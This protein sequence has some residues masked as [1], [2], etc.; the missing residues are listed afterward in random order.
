M[1]VLVADDVRLA[2][3]RSLYSIAGVQIVGE[4]R[5]AE[6]AE[7]L[8]GFTKPDVILVD[9]EASGPRGV[10]TARELRDMIPEVRV[11]VL[12]EAD[13]RD[14]VTQA[15]RAGILGCIV[16]RADPTELLE[17]IRGAIHSRRVG[18]LDLTEELTH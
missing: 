8:A 6:L 7:S 17:A 10:A 15:S 2:V 1:K 16:D 18:F 11:L 14:L 4:A 3:K 5:N 12:G 13:S 9:V